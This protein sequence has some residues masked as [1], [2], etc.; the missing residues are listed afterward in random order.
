MERR[1]EDSREGNKR[2]GAACEE[3]QAE[4]LSGTKSSKIV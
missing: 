1:R 4:K 2:N 3:R